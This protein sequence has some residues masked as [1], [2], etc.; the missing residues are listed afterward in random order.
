MKTSRIPNQRYADVVGRALYVTRRFEHLLGHVQWVTGVDPVWAGF[1]HYEE[2]SLGRSYRNMA[3]CC[4]PWNLD[5]PADQRVT[6][7]M[8]P[9]RQPPHPAILVHELGHA[10]DQVLGFS[11]TAVPVSEYAKRNRYEAFAEA[12][13]AHFYWYE[14]QDAAQGDLATVA[15][16]EGLER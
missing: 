10:L 7:I 8:V 6:T 1:H 12:F 4:Y 11:H 2:A 13:T 9:E 14:D 5:R 15:L 16:F 3:H